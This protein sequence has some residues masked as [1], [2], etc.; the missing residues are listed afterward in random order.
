MADH[1]LYRNVAL[2]QA[3]GFVSLDLDGQIVIILLAG[4]RH[5][6]QKILPPDNFQI[7]ARSLIT[8]VLAPEMQF[9]CIAVAR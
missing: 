2:N 7:L 4:I 3:K 6:S 5:S 8:V 1:V 9:K